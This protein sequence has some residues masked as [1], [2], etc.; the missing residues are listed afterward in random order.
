MQDEE[1]FR[2]KTLQKG[3]GDNNFVFKSTI[4]KYISFITSSI[5]LKYSKMS[6]ILICN[7]KTL[8]AILILL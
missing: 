6:H 1:K 2:K 8:K 3:P 7:F 5:I 4:Q